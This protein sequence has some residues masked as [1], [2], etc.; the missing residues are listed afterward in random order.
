MPFEFA[1]GMS[2]PGHF[3]AETVRRVVEYGHEVAQLLGFE[4]VGDVFDV[5]ADTIRDV[6]ELIQQ[7]LEYEGPRPDHPY[8]FWLGGADERMCQ[9]AEI[10]DRYCARATGAKWESALVPEGYTVY[11]SRLIGFYAKCGRGCGPLYFAFAQ[12][13]P[14]VALIDPPY[15][16]MWSAF[17]DPNEHGAYRISEAHFVQCHLRHVWLFRLVKKRFPYLRIR[18]RDDGEFWQTEDVHRLLGKAAV[19]ACFLNLVA[20]NLSEA[21]FEVVAPDGEVVSSE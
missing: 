9:V 13:P 5:D 12:Y 1:V 14:E 21:G 8:T 15:A 2:L 6:V 4:M 20:N 7:D 17:T 18:V 10:V 11:P 16:N 19:Y 3:R